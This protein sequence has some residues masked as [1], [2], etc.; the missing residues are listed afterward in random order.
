MEYNECITKHRDSKIMNRDR[1]RGRARGSY[2]VFD[3]EAVPYI[4]GG[5]VSQTRYFISY[6]ILIFCNVVKQSDFATSDE[7]N[8]F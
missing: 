2:A 4:L 5:A 3:R 6:K 7:V 8:V 1:N